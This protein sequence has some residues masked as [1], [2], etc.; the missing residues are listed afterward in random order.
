VVECVDTKIRPEMGLHKTVRQRFRHDGQECHG[1]GVVTLGGKNSMTLVLIFVFLI[2]LVILWGL[3]EPYFLKVE[4]HPVSFPYLPES[5]AGQRVALISD[6]HVGMWLA[7]TATIK[8][9]VKRIVQERPALVLIAGD[10]VH[11]ESEKVFEQVTTLLSP[12]TEAGLRC[13]AVLGNHDYDM[14]TEDD[15]KNRTLVRDLTLRLESI[16]IHVLHNE[17]V[18]LESF[19]SKEPLHVVGLAAH[20]P[21]KDAPRE[22]LTKVPEGVARIVLM[23]HPSSFAALSANSAPFAVAGHTHGGQIRLPGAPIWRYLEKR[24]EDEVLT[25]GWIKNYGAAGNHLYVNRGI[26]FSVAPLRLNCPPELT[27][28]TFT[29]LETRTSI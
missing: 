19:E 25:N 16:G 13:Y 2:V 12:L 24:H 4:H 1:D 26:G 10:F 14:P 23:H 9:A 7:N 17:V 15:K 8:K 3:L 28:F 29:K 6:L 27:F 18:A 20:T 22:T 21:D 5:W 11:Q